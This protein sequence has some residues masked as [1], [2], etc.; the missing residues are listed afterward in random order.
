MLVRW[1]SR[2]LKIIIVLLVLAPAIGLLI[3]SV[4]LWRANIWPV[5]LVSV[6]LGFALLTPIV[7]ILWWR[8]SKP[9]KSVFMIQMQRKLRRLQS[10]PVALDVRPVKL[11]QISPIMRLA[12]MVAEDFTF[13]IHYGIILHS[14]KS[15][16]HFNKTIPNKDHWRGGST[17][18]QQ[19]VKNLFL[20]PARSYLRKII[21]IYLTL[22]IEGFWPKRQ[23]LEVYCNVVQSGPLLFGVEAAAQK[24]FG[25]AACG[26][27]AK[28]AALLATTLPNPMLYRVDAPTP[29]MRLR[30]T[31]ILNGMRNIS[32]TYMNY[33]QVIE[34]LHASDLDMLRTILL[35][36]L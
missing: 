31:M 27:T 8:W 36:S 16:Y 4:A 12:I 17:I 29:Q 33:M 32:S 21:E 26:L 10:Q 5:S 22:L 19:L 14:L 6:T 23:I 25:K 11:E 1:Y 20:W 13:P 24:Y 7:P 9:G 34:L 3:V 2:L 18:T 30:Q 15:A 35:S 28:E